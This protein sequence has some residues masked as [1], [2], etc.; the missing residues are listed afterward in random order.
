MRSRSLVFTL[1][2]CGLLCFTAFPLSAQK[3]I[4]VDTSHVDTLRID[5]LN[6]FGGS[7]SEVF[8]T[9]NYIPLETTK[10]SLFGSI[11]QLEVTD[12]YFIILDQNTNCILFF[13][14][15]GKY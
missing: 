13:K 6:S 5:P 9:A 15:D 3:V 8:E 12:Q 7:A 1:S 4:S 14:K 2:L 11:D 10:E